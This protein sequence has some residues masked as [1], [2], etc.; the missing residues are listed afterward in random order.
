MFHRHAELPVTQAY[1]GYLEDASADQLTALARYFEAQARR[2]YQAAKAIRATE[3]DKRQSLRIRTEA[4]IE[5]LKLG[6]RMAALRTVHGSTKAACQILSLRS[7][8][9]P[10]VLRMALRYWKAQKKDARQRP[11]IA[12]V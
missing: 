5:F 3:G 2:L 8:E 7:G 12:P 1:D 9:R 10:D 11:G 4:Q 6:A